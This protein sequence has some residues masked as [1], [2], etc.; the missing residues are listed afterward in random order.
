M[1][2]LCK[3]KGLVAYVRTMNDI[4][5]TADC[6]NLFVGLTSERAICTAFG[7]T[8][9]V[10]GVHLGGLDRIVSRKGGVQRTMHHVLT[11]CV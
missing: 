2:R 1:D 6:P 11:I 7:S 10:G 4:V 3:R 5:R 8:F 9:Y